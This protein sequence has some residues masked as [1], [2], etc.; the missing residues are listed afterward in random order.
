[1]SDVRLHTAVVL[2]LSVVSAMRHCGG[3]GG[4]FSLLRVTP[5]YSRAAV[6]PPSQAGPV[7]RA[8]P[9]E[10]RCHSTVCVSVRGAQVWISVGSVDGIPGL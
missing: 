9:S 3:S 1:M 8:G 4:A 5:S 7:C 10:C 6:G 2:R